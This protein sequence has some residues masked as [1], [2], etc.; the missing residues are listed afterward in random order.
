VFPQRTR[1]FQRNYVTISQRTDQE[2]K[3]NSGN[4]M[5]TYLIDRII[6]FSLQVV[7]WVVTSGV[8]GCGNGY[9][10]HFSSFSRPLSAIDHWLTNTATAT[11]MFSFPFYSKVILLSPIFCDWLSSDRSKS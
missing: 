5:I 3:H 10:S 7:G 6:N 4:L 1:N 2:T 9:F 8:Y 11:P